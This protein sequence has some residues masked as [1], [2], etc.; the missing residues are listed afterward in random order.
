MNK[1]NVH[2]NSVVLVTMTNNDESKVWN[3]FLYFNL[4]SIPVVLGFS[5][6]SNAWLTLHDIQFLDKSISVTAPTA[7]HCHRIHHQ[8]ERGYHFEEQVSCLFCIFSFLRVSHPLVLYASI[9]EIN[10]LT[11]K[12]NAK[13]KCKGQNQANQIISFGREG[14]S[15]LLTRLWTLCFQMF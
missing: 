9:S 12:C 14:K 5:I 2:Q 13:G 7:L 15:S 6:S 11:K 10:Y 4:A 1:M 8:R 3:S